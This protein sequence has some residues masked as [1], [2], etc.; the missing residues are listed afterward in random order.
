MQT[1]AG[2][3]RARLREHGGDLSKARLLE[4]AS[5]QAALDEV[6]LALQ[7]ATMRERYEAL[8]G[9]QA[10]LARLR[11]ATTVDAMLQTATSE[12]CRCCGF[13]RAILFRVV[14]SRM[15][16]VSV[17]YEGDPEGARR[18]LEVGRA[19]LAA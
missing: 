14:D 19:A 17:H 11:G 5:L 6:N 9:V 10:G 15:V 3:V 16:A 18:L 4:L 1:A 7:E 8:V 2:Q 13:D 12:L